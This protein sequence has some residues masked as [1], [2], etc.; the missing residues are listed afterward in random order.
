MSDEP[1]TLQAILDRVVQMQAGQDQLRTGLSEVRSELTQVHTEQGQLRDELANLDAS[2]ARTRT[3]IM[4]RID[5][6]QT[7]LTLHVEARVVDFAAAERAERIAKDTQSQ[8][9]ALVSSLSEQVNGMWRV[10]RR[11]ESELRDLRGNPS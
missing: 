1:A 11:L 5:S 2:L 7:E 3:D 6:M 4:A 8:T 10:V 9:A